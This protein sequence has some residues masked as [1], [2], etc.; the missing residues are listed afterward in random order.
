MESPPIQDRFKVSDFYVMVLI[1]SSQYG[2]SYLSMPT[3]AIQWAGQ[4]VWISVLISAISVHLIIFLM[5]RILTRRNADLIQIHQQLLGKWTGHVFNLLFLCY[6]MVTAAFQVSSYIKLVQAWLFPEISGWVLGFVIFLLVYYIVSGGIRTIAGICA[7]TLTTQVL[8]LTLVFSAPY[9]HF[10]NLT[11]IFEH[12][13]AELIKASKP[14]T[15]SYMGFELLFFYYI[16]VKNAPK[17]QRW[18][19]AGNA[20]TTVTYLLSMFLSI[21]LFKPEQLAKEIWPVMT[22]F[23]FVQLPFLERFEFMGA[24]IHVFR[25][26]PI[27]CL[28]LWSAARILKSVSNMKQK[29]AVPVILIIVLAI[30]CILSSDEIMEKIQTI[31]SN[32]SLYLLYGYIPLLYILHLIRS[33][34]GKVS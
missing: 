6:F 26:M 28:C 29:H 15:F 13:V 10:R 34:A 22:K 4:D 18:A 25:V 20:A 33:K 12:T 16:F 5:Y 11:P 1:H 2:L 32:F 24:A 31:L 17:S 7:F 9:F 23:K 27:V 21:L 8:V 30:F 19:H 3:P 14:I